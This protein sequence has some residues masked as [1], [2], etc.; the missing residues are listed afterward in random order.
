MTPQLPNLVSASPLNKR[1]SKSTAA[2]NRY[3]KFVQHGALS[4]C[5]MG[6]KTC[7]AWGLHC[8]HVGSSLV[9]TGAATARS[10]RCAASSTSLHSHCDDGRREVFGDDHPHCSRYA[11]QAHRR[12]F[13]A[14]CHHHLLQQ[15]VNVSPRGRAMVA[16]SLSKCLNKK[17]LHRD[18]QSYKHQG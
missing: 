5:S 6:L 18:L 9:C 1:A 12:A 8:A 10:W 15:S 17:L 2:C 13:D 11:G 14:A 3:L 4:L 16:M 7:A